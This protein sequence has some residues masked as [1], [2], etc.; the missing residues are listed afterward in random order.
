MDKP[1]SYYKSSAKIALLYFIFS[2]LWIVVTDSLIKYI[3]ID[4][5]KQ[6]SFFQT[7]K[8]IVF[9]MVSSV[10]LYYLVNRQIRKSV[11]LNQR[12]I[13]EKALHKDVEL[14]LS[15]NQLFVQKIS[16]QSPDIIYIYDVRHKKNIYANK[17]IALLLGYPESEAPEKDPGFFENYMHPLDIE[18]F[19]DYEDF[20]ENWAHEY[21]NSFE[22]RLKDS[23]GHWHWF[24][25]NEKEFQRKN[26]KIISII[27]T[28]REI[29][30]KKL[31]EEKL[32]KSEKRFYQVFNYSQTIKVIFDPRDYKHVD[33]NY[34]YERI[35][36]YSKI[37][38]LGKPLKEMNIVKEKEAFFSFISSI[39]PL[40]GVKEEEFT[41]ITK[42]GEERT[43]KILGQFIDID[44]DSLILISGNDITEQKLAE[45][46]L[47]KNEEHFRSIVN[48][49]FDAMYM[50]DF[51][52]K[53]IDVNNAA[54]QSLGYSREEL[55]GMSVTQ[56]DEKVTDKSVIARLWRM[57][58]KSS[59]IMIESVHIKKSGERFPVEIRTGKFSHG[60]ND[61]IIGFVRDISL[62]LK[63]E[64]AL[65]ESELR[66]R[67]II[68][69]VS[70]GLLIIHPSGEIVSTNRAFAAMLG[71]REPE[72]RNTDFGSY[73]YDENSWTLGLIRNAIENQG[74]LES[75]FKMAH[76]KNAVIYVNIKGSAISLDQKEFYLL[77]VRN[78]SERKEME[79]KML[80]A[81]IEGEE[82][83]RERIA[84][85]LHDGLGPV[86]SAI[87]LYSQWLND[88]ETRT[89]KDFIYKNSA[90][91]IEEAI[92]A[93][94]EISGNLSPHVLRNYGLVQALKSFIDKIVFS[95]KI[96]I[97][98]HS[99]LDKKLADSVEITFYRIITEAIANTVKYADAS[100][101]EIRLEQKKERVSLY[102]HD[103]GKGF[104]VEKVLKEPEGLGLRNMVNRVNTLDGKYK[105][106][107]NPENGT[108]IEI[109]F[110]LREQPV[111]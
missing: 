63:N 15:E 31:A 86:L 22:Y 2:L 35:T 80:N 102:Y 109:S 14:K 43:L 73:F 54:C 27:G 33:I 34:L 60:G 44:D 96:K 64:K 59:P 81:F 45:E 51:E 105:I 70:D 48:Q 13:N 93:L 90:E 82:M 46:A 69:N 1:G 50:C 72:L 88:P 76:K 92:S 77:V 55:I 29:T 41:I 78:I 18:Q 98:L 16:E 68:E 66:Y 32:I 57:L 103:N 83:E 11:L 89:P 10:L 9:I 6:I 37:D 23:N 5:I 91:T 79:K 40:S 74:Y 87:K 38:I 104:D 71:Y 24:S 110:D 94:K 36:G 17:N 28:V 25:G 8:G 12:L 20:I 84:R 61:Y 19:H 3:S 106:V 65:K 101:I 7:L 111:D 52:G 58:D 4:N 95:G 97:N 62:R 85:D 39:S 47:R 42:P 49:A 108:K 75:E 100:E 56:T 30:E 21:V 67:T 26:G 53:I 107:S 99:N